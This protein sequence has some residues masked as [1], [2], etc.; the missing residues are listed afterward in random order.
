[1]DGPLLLAEDVATGLQFEYG[2]VMV[3]DKPGLG[4]SMLDS[5]S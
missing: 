5:F 4:I 1:M 3:S 2:N